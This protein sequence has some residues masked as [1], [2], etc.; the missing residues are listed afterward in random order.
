M[1]RP[2]CGQKLNRFGG[3]GGVHTSCS[4]IVG[5]PLPGD[6]G[7][8]DDPGLYEPASSFAVSEAVRGT[9]AGPGPGLP[10]GVVDTPL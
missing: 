8:T 1:V 9:T 2:F 10:V 6:G 7:C 5:D 3:G 4:G